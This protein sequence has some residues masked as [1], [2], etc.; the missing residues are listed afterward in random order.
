VFPLSNIR[1]HASDLGIDSPSHAPATVSSAH[2][3]PTLPAMVVHLSTLGRWMAYGR[4]LLHCIYPSRQEKATTSWH[5]LYLLPRTLLLLSLPLLPPALRA[6]HTKHKSTIASLGVCCCKT[7]SA[8]TLTVTAFHRTSRTMG[9]A[10]LLK[11]TVQVTV[12]ADIPRQQSF[13]AGERQL[14]FA[15]RGSLINCPSH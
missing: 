9:G 8:T 11:Y 14:D 13:R 1:E 6:G 10:K 5:Y 4:G 2:G 12:L 7:P 15:A 3:L